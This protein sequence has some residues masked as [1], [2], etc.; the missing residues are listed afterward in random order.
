M[1]DQVGVYDWDTSCAVV[2]RS[3]KRVVVGGGSSGIGC[4][5]PVVVVV[6]RVTPW[7]RGAEI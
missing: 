5:A 3:G 6:V 1:A 2:V 4:G 7:S